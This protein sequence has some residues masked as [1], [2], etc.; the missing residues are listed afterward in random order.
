MQHSGSLG[1]TMDSTQPLFFVGY[2]LWMWSPEIFNI[3]IF[4][5]S[6]T[7]SHLQISRVEMKLLFR[8]A[9][10][11]FLNSDQIVI[12]IVITFWRVYLRI[13]WCLFLHIFSVNL[14]LLSLCWSWCL[15]YSLHKWSISFYSHTV[16]FIVIMCID[17]ACIYWSRRWFKMS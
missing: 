13:D 2:L 9:R 5:D 15:K 8:M 7:T 11:F 17:N 3:E 1:I 10:M 16:W 6:H 12:P 14:G 4:V